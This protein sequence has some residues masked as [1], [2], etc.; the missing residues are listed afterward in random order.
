MSAGGGPVK[1]P[2]LARQPFLDSRP[3]FVLAGALWILGLVLSLY[4]VNNFFSVRSQ[5]RR[6]NAKLAQLVQKNR[7][8]REQAKLL[9]RELSSVNWKKLKNEV[10]SVSFAASQRRLR[11]GNLLADLEE[12]VPWDVRLVGIAPSVEKDGR[13]RV[14]L[15]GLSTGR[16]AWLTFLARLVEDPRFGDLIPRLEQAPGAGFAGGYQFSL[17]LTYRPEVR[18]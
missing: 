4:S 3:V 15:E 14:N 17:S 18:P 5:E 12:V 2:N 13:I 6:I 8:L 1:R 9:N 10:E 16:E 7:E 11:W